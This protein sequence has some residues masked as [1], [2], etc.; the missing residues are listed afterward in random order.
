MTTPS[1]GL[2]AETTPI[3]LLPAYSEDDGGCKQQGLTCKRRANCLKLKE[4]W[5]MMPSCGL[6]VFPNRSHP[7]KI[8]S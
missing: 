7:D 6:L 3:A 5:T 2:T 1:L 4:I 8:A